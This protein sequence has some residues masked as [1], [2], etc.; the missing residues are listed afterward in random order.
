MNDVY[1]SG[2]GLASVLGSTLIHAVGALRTRG[3][4]PAAFEVMPGVFTPYFGMAAH[5]EDWATRA[6]RLV[7]ATADESGALDCRDGS[8]LVASTSMDMGRRELGG[9][10]DRDIAAFSEDLGDWLA[11]RGPIMTVCTACTSAANAALSAAAMLRCGDADDAVVL[12]IELANRLTVGGFH[13]MQLLSPTGA[14]PLGAERNG[15]VLGEAVAT[16]R[17]SRKR[18]RWR[19]RGGAN[20]VDSSDPAGSTAGAVAETCRKALQRSGLAAGQIGL[21]KLQAAGSPGNDAVEL[22]GMRQVFEPMPPHLA[23]KG[24]LGHTLGAA[25]AAEM[26]LLMAAI[27]ADLWPALQ[28][29]LDP[30]LG[31][32]WAQ[33]RPAG[34]RFILAS[35]LG[36]GGGHTAVVLED[37]EAPGT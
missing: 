32:Q 12:G 10:F 35:F 2:R 20:I 4:P 3:V 5:G 16:L 17:L 23:L 11:W 6:H 29:P 33:S 27:E 37:T 21:I 30:A 7:Q 1:I 26:A 8:L 19:L 28:Y 14:Q 24:W 22:A 25:G 34:L 31:A 9:A 18:S 13:S 15:M 36:F